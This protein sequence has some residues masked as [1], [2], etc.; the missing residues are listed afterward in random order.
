MPRLN[1]AA[2]LEAYRSRL[3]AAEDPSRPCVTICS[4]TGCHASRSDKVYQAFVDE[5]ERNGLSDQVDI[6][7]T[8]C[9]GFCERGTIVTI[10]PQEVTYL[11]VKPEDVAEIVAEHPR[12]GRGH[13]PAALPDDDGQEILREDDIPFY[14][15]QTPV[16]F[17]LN[18]FIDPNDIDS[19]IVHGGYAALAKALFEMTP[20]QV[21]DEVKAADLR[22]RGGGGFP[23]GVKWQTTRD[24]PG[25]IKYVVVNADEGDPGAYMDRSLLEGNPHRVLEGLIIGAYAI[26]AHQGFVYV[27]Q[28]YPIAVENLTVALA[29]G[30]RVRAAR[31]RTSSAPASPSTS[32]STAA[33]APS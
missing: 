15:P 33:P 14:T 21:L 17:G 10:L 2:D 30:A 12:E 23:A 6:L 7:R 20:E 8:G 31:A 29:A 11:Q 24:A 4:G 22:G 32:P 13:R 3:L 16:V 9:H 28:E 26:G 19:Y 5:L 27:R 25:D 1:S 18:R